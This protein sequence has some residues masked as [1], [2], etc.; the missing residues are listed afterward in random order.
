MTKQW[1]EI[2]DTVVCGNAREVLSRMPDGCVQTV[3]TSP[4]Y[5]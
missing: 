4:P 2:I 1:E 5:W 3:I